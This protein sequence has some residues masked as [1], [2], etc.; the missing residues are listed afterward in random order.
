M[1]VHKSIVI[2]FLLPWFLLV[3]RAVADETPTKVTSQNRSG[4]LPFS[5][6]VGTPIEHVDV[7]SGALNIKIPLIKIPG[8]GLDAE[9][10]LRWNSNFYMMAPRTDGYGRGY[11]IW[12]TEKNSGWQTN[13]QDHSATFSH[14]LCT[15]IPNEGYMNVYSHEIYTDPGG[16]KH[17]LAIQNESGQCAS[18]GNPTGP[19][20]TG[21]GMWGTTGG[22]N[23]FTVLMADGGKEDTQDSNGNQVS[24]ENALDT[25]GRTFYTVQ[26]TLDGSG[27][28]TQN[29]YIYKDSNGVSQTYTVNWQLIPITTNFGVTSDGWGGVFEITNGTKNVVTSI[30]LPN[31]RQYTFTYNDPYG[32]ITEIDLPTG[33]V[34]TYTWANLSDTRQTRRYVSARTETVG[35]VQS[36]WQF[37]VS[38]VD[39]FFSYSSTVTYPAVG[40]PPVQ[41]Q[42]VFASTMGAITNAKIYA[43]SA[44]GT[45][46]REY[47]MQIHGDLN[48]DADETCYSDLF[49][50]PSDGAQSPGQRLLSITTI[51]EDGV[52]Q[53]R[54][55]FDYD[56]LTFTFYPRHCGDAADNNTAQQYSTSRGNVTEIRE[57]DWGAPGSMI[58][59]TK[60]TY[61]HDPI[62]NP[63]GYVN[64]LSRNIVDKVLSEMVCTGTASCTQSSGDQASLTQYEYDNYVT[65][66]NAMVSTS[67]APA[68][69]HDYTNYSSGFIYRGNV[70]RVK[71]WRNGDG[72]FLTTTYTYD[73]LGNIRAVADP[74]G[75]STTFAY[76]DKWSV[77]SCP[78]TS[79][80]Y[81]YVT[82]ITNALSQQVQRTYFQC[83]GLL[84]AHQDPNDIAAARSG[85]TYLY[86]LFGRETQKILSDSGQVNTTYNDVPPVTVTSTTKITSS[87]NMVSLAIEDGLARVVQTQVTSDP[88]GI[89][90]VDTAYDALGRKSTV[91]NPHRST[92][93]PTDG[94]TAYAYDPLSRTTTVTKQDGS[95]VLTGYTT[96][97]TTVTDEAGKARKSC[98]DGLGRMTGVREDPAGLNYET[99]Y[100]YD[101]LGNLLTVF[102]KGGDS[103]QNHWRHRTFAYDSLSRLT[104]STNPE[105]GTITYSYQNGT[106][107]CAGDLA[108]VC[109]KTAPAPNQPGSATVTTTYNYDVLNRLTQ[110]SYNDGTTPTAKFGYDHTALTGC[111]P[112]PPS[113]A[114]SNS[115]GYRTAMCDGSGA[116][117]WSHDE[118]GRVLTEKRTIKST[119]N[120]TQ[121]LVY[122]YNLDGSLKTLTYPGTSEKITYTYGGAGRALT[123]KDVA[124]GIN[125]VTNATYAPPGEL[126]TYS[127]GA[128][129]KAAQTF[130]SR[131]QPLQLYFTTGT[132]TSATLNQLAQTSCPTVSA[133]IMSRSYNFGAGTNDN[134]A[135]NAIANCRDNNRSQNFQYDT[136]NRIKQAN[137]T[138]P[139]WGENF[140]IDPWG[141]LTNRAAVPGKTY[142]ELLNVAA[143]NNNQLS[144]FGYDAAGNMTQNGSVTYTY[145]A[146][147]QLVSTAG[148]TYVYDGD[149]ERVKKSNG[150]AGTLYWRGTASEPVA[151]SS[152][153]GTSLEEYIFLG[154]QRVARRDVTGSVVHYYFA[155]HLGSTGMVTNSAGTVPFDEDLDYYPYG[156]IV[157][158]S[159]ENVPQNYKFTGKERDVESRPGQ[160]WRRDT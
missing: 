50:P 109:S 65:G 136:L 124:G 110:T 151:E 96:N 34:I 129:I 148:W 11:W 61:L 17:P 152:L 150:S 66:Q 116:T 80:S 75:N 46:L 26:T 83:T 117:S 37:G 157:T 2:L 104:S 99:D 7:A 23:Q 6:S 84:Q 118:L 20:L 147:N 156:G 91:S 87:L 25:L 4:D 59:R 67:A 57:Y 24:N 155:D 78:P 29:K 63:S 43:G 97:C 15:D 58:R 90:Y 98:A 56:T 138:G 133:A 32:E 160:L 51:L 72:Q 131:L 115:K 112:A 81:A 3:E 111:T 38:V 132:I 16:T 95:Q 139:T 154:G 105:S 47:R 60:R 92:A 94:V 54:K 62:Y 42:S 85:T 9:L 144:G 79:N 31:T 21:A 53:S 28:V 70:T 48:P 64:Y 137:S 19:D 89:T 121:S 120:V 149:G 73:D 71:R 68:P 44:T 103:N 55:E 30:I 45:P 74:A 107:L 27:N 88:D 114:D 8:R 100:G 158:G 12:A 49:P 40:N 82:T 108:D 33:G 86:D 130:N 14:I 125:Y 113:L 93:A 52:T 159:T 126:Y 106:A 18:P 123:A 69:Q 135:V 143:N 36:T 141:N 22:T 13:H 153:S 35:G 39:P 146:E 145:N 119:S 140:T 127:I 5:T 76:T 142:T 10:Y 102:Q 122:T 134:G 41:N 1:R 77:T 101:V 128:S